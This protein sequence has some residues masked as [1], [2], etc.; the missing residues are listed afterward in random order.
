MKSMDET[1]KSASDYYKDGGGS[2]ITKQIDYPS[3]FDARK[4]ILQT[5]NHSIF[6]TYAKYPGKKQRGLYIGLV[7]A[8]IVILAC[9][10]IS[11]I[12]ARVT[13]ENTLVL[14]DLSIS[15]G[16][17]SSSVSVYIAL[18]YANIMYVAKSKAIS[19]AIVD[20][21]KPYLDMTK[22][23]L[24][25]RSFILSSRIM[26]ITPTIGTEHLCETA[27]LILGSAYIPD[28]LASVNYKTPF[29][30]PNALEFI[31][32]SY[33]E[34]V[35]MVE[36]GNI[37]DVY[38]ILASNSFRKTDRTAFY[39]T[40][41]S[42]YHTEYLVHFLSRN[43]HSLGLDGWIW[44]LIWTAVCLLVYSLYYLYW[45]LPRD[46][47]WMEIECCILVLND[48]IL[49]GMPALMKILN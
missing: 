42:L 41:A 27:G 22:K 43:Y 19:K 34:I 16:L 12:V 21:N 37:S 44:A 45:L 39:T 11:I 33:K 15:F 5:S 10:L 20:A 7:F 25:S 9:P 13:I 14:L 32:F 36:R 28:C 48:Y 46:T 24:D 30:L 8:F 47:D 38:E 4:K 29:N 23:A 18:N 49:S 31:D 35:M 3:W 40:A 6:R 26:T 2:S 1:L 17:V